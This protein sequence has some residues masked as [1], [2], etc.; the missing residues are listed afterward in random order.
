MKLPK[1]RY[2]EAKIKKKLRKIADNL[3]HLRCFKIYGNKCE[4]CGEKANQVHHFY[5]KNSCPHLRYDLDNGLPLCIK[6]HAK[7][8]FKDTKLVESLIIKKRG[9]KWFNKLEKKSKIKLS[10]YQTIE[11]Y[12]QNILNLKGK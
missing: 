9:Q 8:H 7:L 5:F 4:V 12:Q 6:C 3:W 10:S 11:W 2:N 1:P